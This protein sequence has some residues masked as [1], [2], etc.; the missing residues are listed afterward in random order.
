MGPPRYPLCLYRFNALSHYFVQLHNCGFQETSHPRGQ[1]T[2]RY[3]TLDV[4]LSLTLV[5][6]IETH[7]DYLTL[8]FK[9]NSKRLTGGLCPASNMHT[10]SVKDLGGLLYAEHGNI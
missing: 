1:L 9:L 8:L 6:V 2:E 7:A 10:V 5:I 4:N 3:R